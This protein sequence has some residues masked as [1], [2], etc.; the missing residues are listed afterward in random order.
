MWIFDA[1]TVSTNTE[2][3]LMKVVARILIGVVVTAMTIW[4]AGM[5]YFAPIVLP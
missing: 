5:L 1:F 4:S 3:R 2:R